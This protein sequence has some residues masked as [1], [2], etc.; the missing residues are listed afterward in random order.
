MGGKTARR[1]FGNGPTSHLL[2]FSRDISLMRGSIK[3]RLWKDGLTTSL[4][5]LDNR[6]PRNDPGWINAR[7]AEILLEPLAVTLCSQ[8]NI[9]DKRG[10]ASYHR[11]AVPPL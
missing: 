6:A 7:R 4:H 2:G 9:I 11:A 5:L 8:C 1:Q 10:N 3:R